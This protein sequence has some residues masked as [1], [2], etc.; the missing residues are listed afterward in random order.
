[1]KKIIIVVLIL[2]SLSALILASCVP[3]AR[4]EPARGWAGPASGEGIVYACTVNGS[5][6]AIDS[7]T[8]NIEWSYAITV[9]APSGFLSCGQGSTSTTI[10]ST[11]VVDGDLVY[12][13]SYSGRVLALST[14]ARE[15]GL[16][17]PQKG[18][19]SGNGIVPAR[20]RKA[21]Q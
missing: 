10:Y 11:P 16:D 13:A 2:I 9:T 3:G 7:S 15:E 5:I 8:R 19:G 21:M 6:L 14:V 17:F 20:A 4:Q 18:T 1:M 12:V